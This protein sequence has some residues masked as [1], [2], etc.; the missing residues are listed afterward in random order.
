MVYG[1]YE[2]ETYGTGRERFYYIVD[3]RD[4]R[5]GR[6]FLLLR[7]ARKHAALLARQAAD[8]CEY[9]DDR[10]VAYVVTDTDNHSV[11]VCKVHLARTMFYAGDG[12]IVTEVNR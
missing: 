12:A 10:D 1:P 2:I 3:G 9:C 11:R 6:S 8:L 4:G 5:V 7:N